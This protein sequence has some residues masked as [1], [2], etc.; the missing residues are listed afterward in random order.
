MEAWVRKI[1]RDYGLKL[2]EEEIRL[3]ARQAEAAEK[4]FEE[5]YRVEVAAVTPILKVDRDPKMQR[6][7]R[8]ATRG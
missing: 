5:L 7:G 8:K 4:L 1:D 2:S 3:I 6:K